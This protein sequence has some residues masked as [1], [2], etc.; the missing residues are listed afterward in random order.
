MASNPG[1]LPRHEVQ[2]ESRIDLV[3]PRPVADDI[4]WTHDLIAHSCDLLCVHDLKGRLLWVNPGPARVLG[5]TVEEILK[6]SMRDIIV[7]EFRTHFDAYLRDIAEKG[8][9]SG[10]MA[11]LTRSGER[12]F[13]EFHNTLRT[14][15]VKT[16]V[17][18]GIAHDITER[19]AAERRLREANLVLQEQKNRQDSLLSGLQLFRTLLDHSND[20][21]EVID[22]PTR[23]LLDVNERHCSQLGYTREELLSMTIFDIDP[24]VTTDQV[25]KISE[26]LQ[27]TGSKIIE[28]IHRRKDGTTFPVE[29]NIHRVQL[30]REYIVSISRDLT[31]RKS[32]DERLKEYARVVNS[33]E[34]MIVVVDRDHRYVLAN[35]AFLAYHSL[36]EKEI[37]GRHL[38]EVLSPQIYESV[39][40]SK[41]EEAFGGNIVS[42]D[43]TYSY[44]ARGERE[45]F[46]T[47][48]PIEG[49][50]GIDRVAAVLRDITDQKRAEAAIRKSEE[51]LG[52][53]LESAEMGFWEH[54]HATNTTTRNLRHDQIFGHSALLPEWTREI[55]L[56]HLAPED[57]DAVRKLMAE[58][59]TSKS[60]SEE[61]PI[62]WPDNSRHWILTRGRTFVDDAGRPLKTLGTVMDITDRKRAEEA[63]RESEERMRLAHEAAQI[64]VFERD[65]QNGGSTWSREMSHMHG[66]PVEMAPRTVEDMLA[67]IHPADRESVRQLIHS[68]VETGTADGEWRIIWPDGSVHWIAGRWRM[69][70]DKQGRPLRALGVDIDITKRK[71]MEEALRASE[72][73]LREAQRV[74]Q[75][76]S[77]R[78]DVKT[79]TLTATEQL[80]HVTGQEPNAGSIPFAELA[81]F[82]PPESWQQI[83]RASQQTV[84]TGQT[85]DLEI[86]FRRGDGTIGWLLT[87]TQID[88]DEA[89]NIAALH[90]I[91]IDVTE[92]KRA[93]Q[94]LRASEAGLR[95]AQHVA[96]MGS[97]RLDLRTGGITGSDELDII[98]GLTESPESIAFT[99]LQKMV[100]PEN[101]QYLV[102]IRKSMLA[103]GQPT[104]F[105]LSFYLPDGST[106]WVLVRSEADCDE[107]GRIVG[108][109]GIAMDIAGRKRAEQALRESEERM[110]LAQQAA[111]IGAFDRD[112]LTGENRWTPEMEK[113]YAVPAGQYPRTVGKF[114]ELVH[115]EDRALVSELINQS[116]NSGEASGEWRVVWPDRSVHWISGHWRVLKDHEGKP[117]RLIGIDYDVTDRKQAEEVLRTDEER[118]RLF[119]EHAPAAL[120]M[121]DREMRYLHTSRRW[122]TD[123]GL[124]ERDLR[125]LSHY[126]VFPDIPE[127]WKEV[128][129]R[130]LSGEVVSEENE[131]FERADG[132]AQW[133]Q[134]EVR[135]WH[136]GTGAVGGIVIFSED[137]TDRMRLQEE[138]RLAKERLTEEKLYLEQEIDSEL[139]FEE[140]IGQ[141]KGLKAVMESVAKVATSDA[142]VLLLGETGTGKELVAR[143]I[144]RLSHRVG[145]AFIKMNCAAIP[146]GLLESE[147]FG[148]E[149]GA[150]TGAVNRKVGR[151]ELADK[152]TIFLDE[153]GEISLALQ[154]KLLRVLQDQEFERLGGTQTLKV[155]FR[156]IAATNRDLAQSVREKEFRSD[157]YY[158]LNVF[159]ILLPPLRERREDIP[160]LVEHF[161]QKIGRR[162]KKSIRS[163]PTRTMDALVAWSW[164]GN[165]RELE[166]FIERSL[167]LSA[168]SVLNAPLSELRPPP[169]DAANERTL[170]DAERLYILNALRES[171]G[172]IS[173][174]RGAANRLG[175]KR[176][177]LQSKLKQ[178][179]I[180]PN[181]ASVSN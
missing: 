76:G 171:H 69:F 100:S 107:T 119:I 97:W 71:Q 85:E 11:V 15:G 124:G 176:T 175:L 95:E 145:N 41:L 19:M 128:H 105:E 172:R 18:R 59:W 149:K 77:W 150:F 102:E 136:D 154:P 101:W 47:Y 125:G 17:V 54:D 26:E 108:F 82:F 63:L 158:R 88:R 115:P 110:R 72:A 153:I 123:F 66:V 22:P 129:R 133:L 36:S 131:R 81:R 173:G 89:G 78:L 27:K 29:L 67:L 75:M 56:A 21:L 98:F 93:E 91:A 90:G 52:L 31:D 144:H 164:P 135:P 65:M 48:L 170:R 6:V 50:M 141:S 103:T 46:V 4:D 3:P 166:N 109:H 161:V 179:G 127:H 9:A 24:L 132:S 74:A 79:Q 146:S 51:R 162:L 42:Y 99:D 151:L 53:A 106:S 160:L 12:R 57:K 94:A 104:E 111:N 64:G 43:L 44:P 80:F 28:T 121:F 165:I 23:R 177:T 37:V 2:E 13:W 130:G 147:L 168:G 137:I 126:E 120:A 148:N 114:I 174:P 92:R 20:A 84:E 58:N 83:V 86:A 116:L 39:I 1:E 96:R 157:L 118:F 159:P 163:I 139:G 140:I 32:R 7:P 40:R 87:R 152:G 178:L 143:A 35:G 25:D 45:L 167:I 68:S 16:P 8:E 70:K 113:I 134:W 10:V 38:T 112:L 169:V 61:C 30:D 180:D 122:R 49:P 156:L 62:V 34:E 33:L 60:F 138:L 142:T 14:E 181:A 55:F 117:V 5:Y 73:E 155:D